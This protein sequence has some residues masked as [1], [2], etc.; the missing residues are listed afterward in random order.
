MLR[1]TWNEPNHLCTPSISIAASGAVIAHAPLIR[2]PLCML[3][4][5]RAPVKRELFRAAQARDSLGDSRTGATQLETA[6]Y[7][8][9]KAFLEAL[10]YACKGEIGGC[11]LVGLKGDEPP[12]VV[13]GELKLASIWSSCCRRSTARARETR[14]G[15]PQKSRRAGKAARAMR[16][17]ATFA[18]GSASACSASAPRA[19]SR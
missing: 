12:V 14:S 6:L 11:D 13:I 3:D 4:R 19:R 9:V 15:S 7:R 18:A 5:S 17:S 8:P 10:G 1:S 16:G 2:R